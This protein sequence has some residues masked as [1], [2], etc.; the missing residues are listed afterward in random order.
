MRISNH[1]LALILTI[2]AFGMFGFGY[3]LVPIYN[4]MCKALGINGK[5]QTLPRQLIIVSIIHAQ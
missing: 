5:P 3:A 2:A 4:V 1:K